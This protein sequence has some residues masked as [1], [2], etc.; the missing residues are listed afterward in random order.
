MAKVNNINQ[1]SN[2]A[3]KTI[4]KDAVVEFEENLKKSVEKLKDRVM[5]EI[6]D[7]GYFRGFAEDFKNTNE[8]VYAKAISL[9]IQ[10]DPVA[11]GR[12]H[13]SVNLLHPTM[14]LNASSELAY[15]TREKILEVMNSPD[16]MKR[17]TEKINKLSVKLQNIE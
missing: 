16:F 5:R 3:N 17:I 15:G 1:I 12:A 2:I 8:N 6:P 9:A 11:D 10:R 4:G 13:L 7:T 14:F